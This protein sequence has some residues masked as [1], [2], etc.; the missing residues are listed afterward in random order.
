M[1][2]RV[3]TGI[4]KLIKLLFCIFSLP[5]K[6]DEF[7]DAS[8]FIPLSKVIAKLYFSDIAEILVR[9]R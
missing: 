4:H 7:I 8:E 5:I 2:T 9:K 1:D 6:M 3:K